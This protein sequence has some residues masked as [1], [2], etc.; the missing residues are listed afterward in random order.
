MGYGYLNDKQYE[1]VSKYVRDRH[2]HDLGAG[3]MRLSIEIASMG[4][5]S[6]VAVDKEPIE[7]GYQKLSRKVRVVKSLYQDYLGAIDIAFVSWPS[8]WET[9]GLLGCLER[10]Q[11]V[12]YLGKNTE[13]TICGT[14]GFYEHLR[15]RKLLE[16]V[17]VRK[18]TLI[19]VGNML[20][21]KRAATFEE[22]A[23]MDLSKQ[24][25]WKEEDSISVAC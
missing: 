10:A 12:I 14:P 3:D 11:L 21:R 5:R 25:P 16:Y 13:G 23:G 18:N 1:T 8:N 15:R 19:I 6:V 17:P 4:A 7:S 24:I 9:P 2:V 20:S 22:K